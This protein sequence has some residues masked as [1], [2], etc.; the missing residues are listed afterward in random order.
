MYPVLP[1]NAPQGVVGGLLALLPHELPAYPAGERLDGAVTT[2]VDSGAQP[3]RSRQ[4]EPA[5][6]LLHRLEAADQGATGGPDAGL[7]GQLATA[8]LERCQRSLQIVGTLVLHPCLDPHDDPVGGHARSVIHRHNNPM[9][10]VLSVN[11]AVPR[12]LTRRGRELPTG[13]WKRPVEGAVAVHELGLDGD[14]QADRRVHGG[15]DKA[16][17]AYASEDVEWWEVQLG[18]ELGPGFFGENLTLR[19]VDVSG[20]PIGERWEIGSTVLEVSEPRRPCWKLAAR[21]GEPRFVK[22]FAE[23]GRPGTYLRVVRG[24]ELRVGDAVV[25]SAGPRPRVSSRRPLL[26]EPPQ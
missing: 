13:L 26:Q 8:G 24:G 25:V 1:Q 16:V 19:G 22:R 2:D 17:Y 20:A 7:R 14:L 4:L 18:R 10:E 6:H 11:L 12:T 21:V 23:A 5:K 3:L 15:R 9:G